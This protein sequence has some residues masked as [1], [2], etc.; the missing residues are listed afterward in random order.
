MV[1]NSYI[2]YYVGDWE[3]QTD[4]RLSIRKV[5]E[6]TCSVSFFGACDHQPILRPWYTGKP[7]VD[8]RAKYIPEDGP[9]LLVELGEEELRFT[10]HLNFEA[11]Y[12]VD[13]AERDALVPC[14]SRYEK[15]SFL[16]QYYA[17]FK[18]LKHYTRHY[19]GQA[20]SWQHRTSP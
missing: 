15:D 14:L 10:L 8:M 3:N 13:N 6:E 11:A 5:D 9:G 2:D 12:I 16:D 1:V 4:N 7:S 17:Y 20:H 19:I 18:P